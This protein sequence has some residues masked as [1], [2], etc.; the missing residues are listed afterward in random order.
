M[1]VV[2]ES[3]ER[4]TGYDLT[5]G[6]LFPVTVIREDAAPIDNVQKFAWA[7]GDYEKVLMY[8]ETPA[9]VPMEPTDREKMAAFLSALEVPAQPEVPKLGY[10]WRL[11]YIWGDSGF[12]WELV[13]DPRAKGTQEN[14]IVWADGAMCRFGY[15]YTDEKTVC[16]AIA[17]GVP[18][19][20][21]DTNYFKE[22]I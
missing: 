22:V 12:L 20:L 21:A 7:D 14:P 15:Y 13:P 5:K 16:L 11:K 4:I 1:R 6:A 10:Q 2:N 17:D 3:C 19:G 18:S 8:R 9:A